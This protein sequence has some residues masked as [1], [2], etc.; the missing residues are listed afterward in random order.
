MNQPSISYPGVENVLFLVLTTR[1]QVAINWQPAA[2][3]NPF[4]L[5][6]T[7]TG[8]WMISSINSVHLKKTSR[9][10]CCPLSIDNSFKLWPAE[11]TGPVDDRTIQR[12]FSSC[13]LRRKSFNN[14]D[15]MSSDKAFLK[16]KNYLQSFSMLE[17]S[18]ISYFGLEWVLKGPTWIYLFFGLFRTILRIPFSSLTSVNFAGCAAADENRRKLCA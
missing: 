12:K 11:N 1:S 9:C 14:V 7:G 16:E 13:L 18:D 8:D 5:A 6:I 2:A 17:H 10:N 4:T 15:I 3:A